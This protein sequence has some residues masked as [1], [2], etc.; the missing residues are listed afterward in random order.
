MNYRIITISR[1]FG[2]GGRTIGKEL[3][4]ALGYK[5]YD[6]ELVAKIAEKSGLAESFI[7]ESGEYAN[8]T[9]GI[10][11]YFNNFGTMYNATMQDEL[12]VIQR[13]LIKELA[14]TSPCVIVGRCADYVLRDREDCLNVFIH[15]DIAFR[16]DRIV[17]LY[18]EKEDSPEQRVKDK[19][20]RRKTYYKYYTNQH[21]GESTNY[22]L[23]LDSGELGIDTCVDVIKQLVKEETK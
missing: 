14:E 7:K 13:N 20:K 23:C 4:D 15:A 21:W 18:G 1:E 9:N 2:S 6:N 19:D 17:H 3:A 5:Y 11:F 8:S 12:Y 10:L 16:A 22:H